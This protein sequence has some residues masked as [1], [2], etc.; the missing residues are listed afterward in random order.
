MKYVPLYIKTHNTL[1]SS[2]IKIDNLITKA[3]E[4]GINALTIT[5]DNMYGCM[6]FYMECKKNGIKPIIGL[7]LKVTDYTFVLYAKD[8]LGYKCLLKLSTIKSEK[9]ITYDDLKKY[10]DN[11]ICI[12]PIESG[13][14]YNNLKAI[15]SDIFI[16]YKNIQERQ[17]YHFNNMVYFNETLY[18]DKEDKK[19][20]NYLYG[21]KDGVLLE[22][23]KIDNS[24]HYLLSY[25]EFVRNYNMD[26]KNN[27]YIYDNCNLEITEDNNLIP[28]YECPNNLDSFSYLKE[29]C[30]DGLKRLFDNPPKEYVDRLNYELDVINNMGFC[31]YFLIVW[32]YVKFA[33]ENGILVGPGR[34]SA[35]ASL[36]SYLLNITTVDPIKYHL[37][38]ER[39]L[40]PM[41]V[42]M[43]DIDIDFEYTKREEVV[44]YCIKKYGIKHVAPII[45]FGTMASKQAIRDVGRVMD[46]NLDVIDSICKQ[47]DVQ[48]NLIDNYKSNE[49]LRQLINMSNNTKTLFK[50]ASK[51]EGIKRHTSIHAAGIV[52]SSKDLDE[53]VPLDKSHEDYYTTGYSMTYLE[54]LGLLKMDFLALRNLTIIKDCLDDMDSDLTF[55]TIP[56]NDKE[57]LKLFYDVNTVG[58]FQFES[59]GMMNFLRKF[60]PVTF[61]DLVVCL[62]LFRPGPMNNI[63]LYIN[64]RKG[65]EKVDYFHKDFEEILKPTYGIIVYQEQIM[66]LANKMAGYSYGEADILRRAISKKKEDVLIKERERFVQGSVNKGYGENLSNQIYDLI[67]KFAAYGFNRAHSVSYAFISYKMAYLKVHYPLY[68]MKQLLNGSIGSETKTKDYV[69]ECKKNNINIM[70]PNIN[71]SYDTFIVKDNAIIFSLASIKNIGTN[72]ANKIVLEREK[73]LFKD[74]FDFISRVYSQTI[75]K[76]HIEVLIDSGCLDDFGYNRKTLKENLD[77]II[78]YS[79]IGGLLDDEDLKPEIV[80]YNEYSKIELMKNELSVYGFYLSNNPITEIKLKY[81]NIVN[82]NDISLYFDKY[83]NIIV[84]VDSIREIKTK[85]GDKMSFI[86]ASDEVEKIEL[87]LFPKFYKEHIKVNEGDII[88]VNGKVE[89]RFD[90]YQ[91]VVSKI[92]EMKI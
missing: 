16:G 37:I 66:Q 57:T 21:I 40:N 4:Y 88:L 47:I 90:K 38:F 75:N 51:L 70:L 29:L 20:L 32:D 84:Y 77:L 58:I 14:I 44:N 83:V 46:M 12:V 13:K 64:R 67:V 69:Y 36:V 3:K 74:I 60:K 78:N 81:Q 22:N 10:H 26:I 80:K 39:F 52:M 65:I 9:D 45:T 59:S 71:K 7:C 76:K 73:G 91:I 41:R 6:D 15:Y 55:D 43:P 33:K 30:N 56:E 85:N 92:E 17:K 8:E 31:N 2:M 28:I 54:Q 48:K 23:I 89:K 63:D 68:F 79:E 5:D 24:D 49:K 1:L 62:A 18:L 34:G 86:E 72:I 19:Y 82:L 27:E 35:A 25:D 50:V 11:L 42:T 61:E 53:I 87:V